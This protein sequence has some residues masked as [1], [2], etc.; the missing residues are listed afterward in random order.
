ML[1]VTGQGYEVSP[2][3]YDLITA[4]PC[5]REHLG[6]STEYRLHWPETTRGKL[7]AGCVWRD[8]KG[9]LSTIIMCSPVQFKGAL[10]SRRR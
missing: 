1:R 7:V 4:K 9:R 8:G 2:P 6:R 5:H 3:R 10:G